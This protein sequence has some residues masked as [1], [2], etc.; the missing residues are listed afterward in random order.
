MNIVWNNNLQIVSATN[1]DVNFPKENLTTE[2]TLQPFKSTTNTT[3]IELTSAALTTFAVL[4]T[5]AVYGTMYITGTN[6]TELLEDTTLYEDTTYGDLLMGL[7]ATLTIAPGVTL[8]IQPETY[9]TVI[10]IDFTFL[11]RQKWQSLFTLSREIRNVNITL[12]LES[13]F[14]SELYVG[15]LY[16]GQLIKYGESEYPI[17][18]S[19]QSFSYD[20]RTQNGTII[21]NPNRQVVNKKIKVFAFK[22]DYEKMRLDFLQYERKKVLVVPVTEIDYAESYMTYGRLKPP[23]ATEDRGHIVRYT[24]EVEE[25]K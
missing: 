6:I 13:V 25:T 22:R 8:T 15:L 5:N 9:D 19:Y 2:F 3:T 23:N 21:F 14:G 17:D 24:V 16:G 7:G 4:N 18:Y 11:G 12:E 10:N 1:E 20:K